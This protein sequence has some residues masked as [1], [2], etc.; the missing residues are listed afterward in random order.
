VEKIIGGGGKGGQKKEAGT[1][2]SSEGTSGFAT[3]RKKERGT[4]PHFQLVR[5][6]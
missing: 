1:M 4:R 6:M 2:P 3:L 5:V